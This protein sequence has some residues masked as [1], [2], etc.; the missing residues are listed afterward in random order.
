[1]SF[2]VET[3][4]SRITTEQNIA[5][6]SENYSQQLGL[7]PELVKPILTKAF[8]EQVGEEIYFKPNALPYLFRAQQ[9]QGK[10]S[11]EPEI[12]R[13]QLKNS[14][15]FIIDV[16][17]LKKINEMDGSSHDTGD[18]AIVLHTRSVEESTKNPDIS[19]C[20]V[21]FMGDEFADFMNNRN[22]DINPEDIINFIADQTQKLI[23]EAKKDSS[24]PLHSIVFDPEKLKLIDKVIQFAPLKNINIP[25]D[26][27]RMD[28]MVE[29]M[30]KAAEKNHNLEKSTPL[31]ADKQIL[32][33]IGGWGLN[34]Y[35]TLPMTEQ[36]KLAIDQ[37]VLAIS[38]TDF[39]NNLDEV[40][41]EKNMPRSQ[42]IERFLPPSMKETWG[43]T[44]ALVQKD[45][46]K[47]A[48]T[49]ALFEEALFNGQ[50][51]RN[52]PIL[53]EWVFNEL[54]ITHKDRLKNMRMVSTPF[55]KLYN[56]IADRLAA[57]ALI[58]GAAKKTLALLEGSK[59]GDDPQIQYLIKKQ[60]ASFYLLSTD[61]LDQKFVEK[62]KASNIKAL[63]QIS[64]ASDMT[65][66]FSAVRE[67]LFVT[68]I[69]VTMPKENK[70]L[71]QKYESLR[72]YH[73]LGEIAQL[74]RAC[75][76]EDNQNVYNM[77]LYF[78]SERAS[79]RL[80]LIQEKLS[81]N[82]LKF[83]QSAVEYKV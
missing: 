81:E 54:A 8:T 47:Y 22:K 35:P 9:L 21:R 17:N 34:L 58:K 49:I 52:P 82:V 74:M 41:I 83:F 27:Q 78:L 25:S 63:D 36:N 51:S 32:V 67:F 26:V 37:I 45:A 46:Q 79:D 40:V 14:W 66:F 6:L 2:D 75:K 29:V 53:N 3:P 62:A 38:G 11:M 24:H 56:S 59:Q 4:P 18:A 50:F 61:E 7:S 16:A 19:H 12:L 77:L 60:G 73:Y 76:K 72:K 70:N 33:K 68:P 31:S 1:M 57:T 55:A 13:N 48:H 15:L 65:D 43:N 44:K 69:K 10:L 30:F 20:L 28:D 64:E 71:G 23:D 5:A 80:P 39:E 42:L